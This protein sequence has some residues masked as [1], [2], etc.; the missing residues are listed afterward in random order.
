V[1]RAEVDLVDALV[2]LQ[3][4]TLVDV[5]LVADVVGERVEVRATTRLFERDVVREDDQL[6]AVGAGRPS[7][8]VGVVCRRIGADRRCFRW[9]EAD[10][11]VGT[12]AAQ[13]AVPRRAF[14]KL[15][16]M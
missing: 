8:E 4:V 10:A 15:R 1:L 11:A 14:L 9:L 7:V 16:Y 3:V 2:V 6:V 5:D 12:S 13:S